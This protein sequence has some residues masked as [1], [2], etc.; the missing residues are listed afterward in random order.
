MKALVTRPS[1]DSGAVAAALVARGIEPL[2]EPLLSVRFAADGAAHLAPLLPGVQAVLFTSVNGVRA[3]AHACAERSLPAFAVGDATAQTA[4][5][6]G[7]GDV[8]SA[9]GNVE[10]LARLIIG[11][12]TPADG[13][14]LHAAASAVA[15]DLAGRLAGAGFDVRRAILYEAVPASSFSAEAQQAL[16]AGEVDLAL[17]F[18][19]RTAASFVRLAAAAGL[20]HQCRR[21]T[22]IALSPAV[23]SAVGAVAWRAVRTADAPTMGAMLDALDDMASGREAGG[24]W[25]DKIRKMAR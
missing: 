5:A 15:G 2:L 16:T 24:N 25:P 1:E 11:R 21:M 17:F 6:A 13:A 20:E 23:A 10:D 19:P 18:S 22:A 3:F 12:L 4:S 8:A 7:F 14:L 9:G